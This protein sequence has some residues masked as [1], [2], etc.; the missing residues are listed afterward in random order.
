MEILALEILVPVKLLTLNVKK[1][2]QKR[3]IPTKIVKL[4]ADFFGSFICKNFKYCLKKVSFH[5]FLN[6]LCYAST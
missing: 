6:M 2:S 3:D 4:K 1:A 5:V